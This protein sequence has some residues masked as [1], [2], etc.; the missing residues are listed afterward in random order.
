MYHSGS[1][2]LEKVRPFFGYRT[3]LRNAPE[4]G[5]STHAKLGG[6]SGS[7]FCL[8]ALRVAVAACVTPR[9][10][11]RFVKGAHLPIDP[12]PIADP[13]QDSAAGRALQNQMTARQADAVFY[14]QSLRVSDSDTPSPAP[15]T[16]TGAGARPW[17][18]R[19]RRRPRSICLHRP[20]SGPGRRARGRGS[21]A[22]SMSMHDDEWILSV[23][24]RGLVRKAKV[25]KDSHCVVE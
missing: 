20:A 25:R 17:G 2:V 21:L 3:T 15:G 16:V 8:L 22:M 7:G 12:D 18:S 24:V 11:A 19:R 9:A 5:I 14:S 10:H 1:L 6:G 23:Q 13:M 4:N